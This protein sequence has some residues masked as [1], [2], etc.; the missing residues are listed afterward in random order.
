MQSLKITARLLIDIPGI[1]FCG[2]LR[3][4]EK[5]FWKGTK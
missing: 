4:L 1:V 5:H 3:D 2:Q